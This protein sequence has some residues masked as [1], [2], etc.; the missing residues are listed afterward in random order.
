[1]FLDIS[2]AFDRVWHAGLIYKL[3]KIG[4]RG[5]LLRWLTSYLFK[6]SQRV[7]IN[8]K[9]S[10]FV[11]ITSGV[12]QGSILGPLLFLIYFND[13]VDGIGNHMFLFA[14]DTTIISIDS[15]WE[16][17]QVSLNEDLKRL[18]KWSYDW[19]TS[20]NSLK[21]EFMM[22][23]N[24][25]LQN[26]LIEL[27]LNHIVLSRVR[28]HKH[29]GLVLNSEL[30][31][32]DHVS[33]TCKRVSKRLGLLHKF[34]R[35]LNRATLSKLYLC[36]IRPIIE[37]CS[38]C[39]DNLP[40]YDVNQL[41]K[42][43]RRA[44]VICTGALSR[45]ETVKILADLGWPLLSSR[46]KS[47]KLILMYKIVNRLTPQYLFDDY[48][49]T[50]TFNTTRH[51]RTTNRVSVPFSRTLKHKN[52]FFPSTLKLWNELTSDLADSPSLNKFKLG[53]ICRDQDL[54]H[55]VFN[56]LNGFYATTLSQI[57]LG[58][59]NLRG[60]LFK[61]F[62]CDNPFC[63]LCVDVYESPEHFFL[64]CTALTIEREVFMNR[65]KL[66]VPNLI[67]YKRADL[68]NLILSGVKVDGHGNDI[69]I[70]K[71]SIEFLKNSSR[72]TVQYL[73]F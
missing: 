73:T 68:M 37:Y 70:L 69:R 3:E 14:D 11:D 17:V 9:F 25:P 38:V 43:Q 52:S 1:M 59:S 35:K 44:A 42:L 8:G 34:K 63:P 31:W 60:Q 32:K 5:K 2:K 21:T 41:E 66:L 57:R 51:L 7:L 48:Q 46:R 36:W 28:T 67:V 27:K 20:F 45:T 40:I 61:Y 4:V 29:L 50:Q 53:L 62:L 47:S 72:F 54:S 56:S 71:E 19:L 13:I 55:L 18:E 30:T 12:P 10:C 22:F 65:L 58:L 39:Y 16:N 26:Y 23:A 33:Y 64:D 6:R 49:Q 24:K 15:T